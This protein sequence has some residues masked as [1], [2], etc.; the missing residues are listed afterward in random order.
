MDVGAVSRCT[1]G[2]GSVGDV[3]T[4]AV[5]RRQFTASTAVP[6]PRCH[7]A[8]ALLPAACLDDLLPFVPFLG[9]IAHFS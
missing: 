6:L 9:L 8:G 3:S 2:L 1:L 5:S 4:G 7:G